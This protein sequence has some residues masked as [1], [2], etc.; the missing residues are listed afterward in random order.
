MRRYILQR[1]FLAVLSSAIL[2]VLVYYLQASFGRDPF[3]ENVDSFRSQFPKN[4]PTPVIID[5]LHK[6]EGFD[7]PIFVRFLSW[8]GGILRGNTGK[9][10]SAP[11]FS[12]VKTIF[13]PLRFT[14]LV[15]LPSLLI[16]YFFG[17]LCGLIAAVRKD[18]LFDRITIFL[19]NI[20]IAVPSFVISTVVVIIALAL[21]IPAQFRRVGILGNT[22]W[23]SA[24]SL[25]PPF[26]SLVIPQ[27]AGHVVFIRNLT[28]TTLASE[29]VFF[30]RAKGLSKREV[31]TRYVLRNSLT[32]LL[33]SFISSFLS[34][35]TG[36]WVIEQIFGIPGSSLILT[37]WQTTGEINV[38]MFNVFYITFF[39]SILGIFVDISYSFMDPRIRFGSQRQKPSTFA[40]LLNCLR[41]RI[42]ARREGKRLSLRAVTIV[43]SQADKRDLNQPSGLKKIEKEG[44]LKY[45]DKGGEDG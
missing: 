11:D 19:T 32:P 2:C 36:S 14:I 9:I 28:V 29:Y 40:Y 17:I 5:T 35:Y 6:Q 24:L 26:I 1:F 7:R 12:I 25:I 34:L 22:Y 44:D 15:T 16:S 39:F 33:G 23:D 37:N 41:F 42:R 21:N 13:G 20:F 45:T 10:Y 27:I 18:K 8:L 38:I 4:T 3:V 43:G 30:A 31:F